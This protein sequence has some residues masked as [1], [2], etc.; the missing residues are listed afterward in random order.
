MNPRDPAHPYTG[1]IGGDGPNAFK[2]N[3][4][5]S[6]GYIDREHNYLQ[7]PLE[8]Y[9]MFGQAGMRSA[10]NVEAF[11][12]ARFS[13]TFARSYGFVSGRVQRLVA[14]GAVQPPRYDDPASPQFM[15]HPG[16]RRPTSGSPATRCAAEP[17]A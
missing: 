8:R 6:L 1:P 4:D 12:T 17:R 11:S 14:D 16:H 13:E 5:G 2:Y 9:S 3:P 7:L 10:D 15:Q